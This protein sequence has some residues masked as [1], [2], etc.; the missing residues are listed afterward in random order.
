MSTTFHQAALPPGWHLADQAILP[1]GRSLTGTAAR[2]YNLL[3]ETRRQAYRWQVGRHLAPP[4][5]VPTWV[6]R[7]PWAGGAAGD[8]RLRDLREE[9]V[10]IESERFTAGTDTP[11]SASW[12]W[13]L[14][15]AAVDTPTASP[16][17]AAPLQ[18]L[19]VRFVADPAGAIDISPGASSY[20]AP[21]FAACDDA[22]YRLELLQA[23]HTGRL[24]AALTGR[25]HCALWA[26]P[27]AAYDPRPVLQTAL[28][29]LG[30]TVLQGAL[31]DGP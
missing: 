1:G 7:E 8:R 27:I 14:A 10:A 19:T 23:F 26:D 16:T 2:V 30:A 11:D 24:L 6:L 17:A 12:L 22:A 18:G 20:L 29:K 31:A 15:A 9:G 25:Q 13:R 5:W 4:G 3:V 28:T 21:S